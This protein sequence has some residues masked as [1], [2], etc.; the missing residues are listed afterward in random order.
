MKPINFTTKERNLL[1]PVLD[2]SRARKVRLYLV[3]GILRDKLIGRLKANLDFDF[4]IKKGAI[5]FCRQLAKNMRAGFVVLD[6]EHGACR[7][8]KKIDGSFC[9]FDFS[10]FRGKTLKEDLL[11][12]DLIVNTLALELESVFGKNPEAA[13]LDYYGAR[14]DLKKKIIRVVHRN[15]FK[16]DPIRILRAFSY[17]C[18]LSFVIDKETLKLAKALRTKLSKVSF[19]RV[20]DELFKIF[21]SQNSSSYI[22]L[23]D[24]LKILEVL[25]PEFK[26]MRN[27]GQGPYHHLDV[28][29]HTLETLKQMDLLF[30]NVRHE[31]INKYLNE[32]ISSDRKRSALLKLG[33]LLHDIGKPKALRYEGKKIIFHG[34]EWMGIRP[35]QEISRRLKLSNEEIFI[36]CKIVRNHLRP[37][38][39]ADHEILTARAKFRFFRDAGSEAISTLLLS[40]SDQRATKGP[41][42]TALSRTRHEKLVAKLIKEYYHKNKQKKIERLVNGDDLI[43]KFKL[44]PSPLIGKI[45]LQLEE[46]Q[47]IGKVKT[48][49]EA[50]NAARKLIK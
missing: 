49:E 31:E 45:L 46:L 20:R 40:L 13:L 10:D 17:A 42:T 32:V 7:I 35:T 21:D 48:K 16:E 4:A 36:L 5:S 39:L 12:R 37:G 19:E 23:L 25:F 15:S 50:M 3:G 38:F 11:G 8:V 9:T 27:I 28:W 43:K 18:I 6:E 41:L 24:E 1:K 47:A 29:Q 14:I 44:E 33:A 34:H 30:K 26:K 2:F 22:L